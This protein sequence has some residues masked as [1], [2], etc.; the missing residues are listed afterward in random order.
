[1][2][3]S[4]IGVFLLASWPDWSQSLTKLFSIDAVLPVV[5]K[6]VAI[7]CYELLNLLEQ[8]RR[9]IFEGNNRAFRDRFRCGVS[10]RIDTVRWIDGQFDS[11]TVSRVPPEPWRQVVRSC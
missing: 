1:V 8:S 10:T 2:A 5:Q 9:D 6:G 3:V 11:W 4:V 7:D